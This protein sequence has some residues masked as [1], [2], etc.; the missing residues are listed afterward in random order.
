MSHRNVHYYY[1]TVTTGM[2]S[3]K[4]SSGEHRPSQE[5]MSITTT[6]KESRG[7]L[8]KQELE[9]TSS[10]CHCSSHGP[11]YIYTTVPAVRLSFLKAKLADIE[12]DTGVAVGRMYMHTPSSNYQAAL[13]TLARKTRPEV[14]RAWNAGGT[15]TCVCHMH[16][17][18]NTAPSLWP[19]MP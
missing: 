1:Y 18:Y 10:A 6:F 4:M 16:G 2:I 7:E 12:S 19:H 14:R 8:L 9:P 17:P 3:I 15:R 11:I 5:T 13:A